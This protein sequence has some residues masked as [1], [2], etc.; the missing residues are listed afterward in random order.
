MALHPVFSRHTGSYRL[1]GLQVARSETHVN[2]ERF[3]E[4]LIFY[5]RRVNAVVALPATILNRSDQF[6]VLSVRL[7]HSAE[8]CHLTHSALAS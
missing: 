6:A 8:N 4:K 7:T 5:S 2:P 3:P 1:S